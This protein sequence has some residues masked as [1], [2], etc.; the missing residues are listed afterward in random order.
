MRSARLG[1][2]HDPAKDRCWFL[3][4]ARGGSRGVPRKNV[5]RLGNKPLIAHVLDTL[6]AA[7]PRERVIV[8]TDD[9]EVASIAGRAGVRIF[10]EERTTGK[11]TLD[12]VALEACRRLAEEG[13]GAEDILVTVQPTS[14]FISGE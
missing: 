2:M 10:R 11:A 6:T 5:L 4:P 8:M 14:P 1:L 3:V 7:W 9:D 13:A 12:H